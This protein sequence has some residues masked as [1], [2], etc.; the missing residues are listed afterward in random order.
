[1]E[2]GRTSQIRRRGRV[3]GKAAAQPNRG[4]GLEHGGKK[5]NWKK[6]GGR[7]QRLLHSEGGRGGDQRIKTR[8]SDT[9][10]VKEPCPV[11]VSHDPWPKKGELTAPELKRS[12]KTIF[13]RTKKRQGSM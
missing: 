10:P 8:T 5:K 6:N 12:E 3:P 7:A 9:L 1:M 11:L 4:E 2:R 13:P